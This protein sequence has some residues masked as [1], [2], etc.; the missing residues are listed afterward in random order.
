M[1]A[2]GYFPPRAAEAAHI[3]HRAT[4]RFASRNKIAVLRHPPLRS[5][6][7][8]SRR[9]AGP[10]RPPPFVAMKAAMGAAGSSRRKHLMTTD[11]DDTGYPPHAASATDTILTEL[12]LHGY[13]PFEDE[14]DPRP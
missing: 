11:C 13:R 9:G 4:A 6:R 8:A 12:Q 7:C 2:A 10:V 3:I 1:A 14:P 5:G